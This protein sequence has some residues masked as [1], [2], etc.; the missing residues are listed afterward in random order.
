MLE[1]A[2]LAVASALALVGAWVAARRD[3][4]EE[5]AATVRSTRHL[6]DDA[7]VATAA[8]AALFVVVAIGHRR[9]GAVTFAAW[10]AGAC[11]AGALASM[12][13]RLW[14]ERVRG[15]RAA[16][17]IGEIAIIVASLGALTA[18]AA[19]AAHAIGDPQHL[20]AQV[21][22]MVVSF[23]VGC[24]A[25]DMADLAL[26][27]V[28]AMVLASYFF[29]ANA[30]VLRSA[31]SYASALGIV[32]FPLAV[33]ALGALGAAVAIS[34]RRPQVAGVLALPAAAAAAIAL[35]GWLWQ[36]FALCAA[37]GASMTL[38]PKLA[39]DPRRSEIVALVAFAFA[40]I[41][42]YAVARH[43][44]LTHSGPFGV[45]VAA[46]AAQSAALIERPA[47]NETEPAIADRQANALAA[48]AIGLAVLDGATLFRCTR[49]ADAAHAPSLDTA[50]MLAHCTYASLAPARID[51]SHPAT[52]A[53]ALGGI[54]ACVA[55]RPDASLR[56]RITTS[57]IIVVALAA[58]GLIAHLAF[59]VGVEAVAAG[60]IASSLAAALFP[61]AC[62]RIVAATIAAAALALGAV[63]G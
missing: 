34:A 53:S 12:G 8:S 32:L 18:L 24:A 30:G 58:T 59:G 11:A 26:P 44:G 45:A 57:V 31:P 14:R 9:S 22:E 10:S 27:A 42:G 38:A 51:I 37:I 55:M 40:A 49:F 6:R 5:G 2:L 43:S 13:A 33:I 4:P 29:D 25:L 60:T 21:P 28:S 39:R 35:L 1:I 46:L 19:F 36:P 47:E 56:S 17:A 15:S 62:S 16:G 7:I 63:I 54:A 50:T 61:A 3:S 48:I 52:L 41:G 20:A 23:A